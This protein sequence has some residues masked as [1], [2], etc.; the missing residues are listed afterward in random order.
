M[1]SPTDHEFHE[2]MLADFPQENGELPLDGRLAAIADH[3]CSPALAKR[4]VLDFCCLK[5]GFF[6]QN[7]PLAAEVMWRIAIL[8]DGRTPSPRHGGSARAQHRVGLPEARAGRGGW[9]RL[10]RAPPC[11]QANDRAAVRPNRANRGV[12]TSQRGGT[13]PLLVNP[14]LPDGRLCI[15]ALRLRATQCQ[16]PALFGS[17]SGRGRALPSRHARHRRFLHR[18]CSAA[19]GK[20]RKGGGDA[21]RLYGRASRSRACRISSASSFPSGSPSRSIR[22]TSAVSPAA[23]GR[24]RASGAPR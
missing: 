16:P 17:E 3:R 13:I 18:L 19:H 15:Q 6:L 23:C 4:A 5:I 24:G 10:R 22:C 12:R 1:F 14:P 21:R 20:R 9:R 11:T 7:D 8:D 2:W